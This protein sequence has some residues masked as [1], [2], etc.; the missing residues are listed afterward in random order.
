M[1]HAALNLHCGM[2]FHEAQQSRQYNIAKVQSYNLEKKG[3]SQN[4]EIR[5][6]NLEHVGPRRRK[7]AIT[8]MMNTGR[9][10]ITLTRSWKSVVSTHPHAFLSLSPS[11]VTTPS[12]F[13]TPT[14]Q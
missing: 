2:E 6:P 3:I 13:P 12:P 8:H 5:N 7:E 4:P 1:R 9:S 10:T 11:S 14:Q